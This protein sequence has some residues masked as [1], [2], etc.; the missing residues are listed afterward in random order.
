MKKTKQFLKTSLSIVLVLAMFAGVFPANALLRA[1]ASS[2]EPVQSKDVYNYM[3]DFS[4]VQGENNWYYSSEDHVTYGK[5]DSTKFND[6][7]EGSYWSLADDKGTKL[8]KNT[9]TFTG[10]N[11]SGILFVAPKSGTI[12]IEQELSVTDVATGKVVKYSIYKLNADTE[13]SGLV[14]DADVLSSVYP[15]ATTKLGMNFNSS[16][17]TYKTYENNATDTIS[18]EVEVEAGQRILF[19]AVSNG[20]AGPV[21]T[22]SKFQLTYQEDAY[23]YK[24][25]FSGVQGQNGWYYN[26]SGILTEDASFATT[27]YEQEQ[28]WAA[29]NA[30]G[31][32]RLTEFGKNSVSITNTNLASVIFEVPKTGSVQIQQSFTVTKP[33]GSTASHWLKY[34][35]YVVD[36]NNNVLRTA[37]PS[38]TKTGLAMSGSDSAYNVYYYNSTESITVDV[39]ENLE[40]GQKLYFVFLSNKSGAK[41]RINE[42]KI[43]YVDS[44]SGE[45]NIKS[46]YNYLEDFSNA[47]G[48]DNWYYSP[49]FNNNFS[50]N[51]GAQYN[52]TKEASYWSSNTGDGTRL[53]K[54]Q[55]TMTGTNGA[56]VMFVAPKDGTIQIEQ[57][58]NVSGFPTD[59]V[60]KY[61]IYKAGKLSDSES[62]D[63]MVTLANSD[64]LEYVYPKSTLGLDLGFQNNVSSYKVYDSNTNTDVISEK[65]EVKQGDRIIFRM[66][67]NKSGGTPVIAFDAFKITYQDDIY[68]YTEGFSGVQGQN[69]W[70]Y[71]PSGILTED[72]AFTTTYYEQEKVWAAKNANGQKRL[73]EFGKDS[74]SITNTNL[75]SIMFAVPKAGSVQIQQSFT[76]TKPNES[77]ASHWL[78]YGIYVVD[79]NNNVLRTAFP[80][81]T[82]TGLAM[83]GSDSAYNVYYY[84][85][86]Q[87]ITIDITENLEAGQKLYFVFFSNKSGAKLNIDEFKLTYVEPDQGGEGDDGF[88]PDLNKNVY[89]YTTDFSGIQGN[90]CWYYSPYHNN[91]Y[92]SANES[93]FNGS[94]ETAY[95]SSQNGQGTQMTKN[96]FAF[97]DYAPAGI[98]F[99]APKDGTLQIEQ[100]LSISNVAKDKY[101]KYS[102]YHVEADS[103]D[104][105]TEEDVIKSVYPKSDTK[106]GFTFNSSSSTYKLYSDG[107]RDIIN[108]GVEV[109]AGEKIVFQMVSNG[110]AGPV[111]DINTFKISYVDNWVEPPSYEHTADFSKTQQGPAWYYMSAE[112]GKNYF[113]ELDHFNTARQRWQTALEETYITGAIG[114]H[115][116]APWVSHDA[117]WPSKHHIR[118]QLN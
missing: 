94:G 61:G 14:E 58:L 54:Q 48:Q 42:F 104:V 35:V 71:I 81:S 18:K 52:D 1:D 29:K 17:S 21:V 16:T 102:I 11:S 77:T 114:D 80:N 8:T 12:K 108:K 36:A 64:L 49:G 113:K 31:Q 90:E 112:V 72:A 67:S 39:A 88:K 41:L 99:V 7:S 20:G 84:N 46:A 103:T 37:F 78:K 19:H 4:G 55:F 82:K 66:Q 63:T 89:D 45:N 40:A 115:Y 60:V 53:G 85:S 3:E 95:W 32:K 27:Y 118:V 79:A 26:P 51:S 6:I 9:I 92:S 110:G 13:N 70:F 105:L 91:D 47:Q 76:V 25:G 73:T 101:I 34:G 59:G 24:E 74:V 33:S 87:N 97:T 109:K 98:M 15:E 65:V 50:A 100:D 111:I 28:V 10:Y 69:G 38:N 86:T 43:T 106:L 62:L 83:S 96:S 5:Q 57:N 93:M 117:H 2:S 56:G 22:F 116:M 75:A 68:D 107:E 23:D 30:N 44:T